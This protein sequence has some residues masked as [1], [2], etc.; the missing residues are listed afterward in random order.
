MSAKIGTKVIREYTMTL[1]APPE[2][3][4]PLLCPVREHEWLESW[5]ARIVQ[6]ESGLAEDGCVFVTGDSDSAEEIWTV[7]GHERNR[8]VA[9]VMVAPQRH[10]MRLRIDIEAAGP[11]TRALWTR[12]YVPLSKRGDEELSATGGEAY[13][14]RMQK[15]EAQLDHFLRTGAMLGG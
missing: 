2:K 14:E 9:F 13:R 4:F 6:T 7:V 11:G 12:T 1:S 3:V 5:H 15:L 8:S 10:V